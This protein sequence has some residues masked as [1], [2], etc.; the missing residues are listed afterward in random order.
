MIISSG[1]LNKMENAIG[2]INDTTKDI[3]D[4]YATTDYVMNNYLTKSSAES[5]YV[6][7]TDIGNIDDL[8]TKEYVDQELAT[9]S[10]EGLATEDYVN[11]AIANID[12]PEV[13]LSAYVTN[14]SLNER[15]YVNSEWV[16]EQGYITNSTLV[17]KDYA[18]VD[19]VNMKLGDIESI[20]RSINGEEI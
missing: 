20:L 17:E 9:I 3:Q 6:A 7:K 2:A 16:Y 4:D 14:E 13:D 12:I 11:N 15:G 10:F 18:S 5:I 19:Y 1:K 8:A